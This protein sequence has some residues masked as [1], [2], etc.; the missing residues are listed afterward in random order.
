MWS[1]YVSFMFRLGDTNYRRP[2]VRCLIDDGHCALPPPPI[3]SLWR[4][5]RPPLQCW[6]WR[7][8]FCMWR[9]WGGGTSGRLSRWPVRGQIDTGSLDAL[10]WV[11]R[12]GPCRHVE[13]PRSGECLSIYPCRPCLVQRPCRCLSLWGAASRRRLRR[14]RV[15]VSGPSAAADAAAVVELGEGRVS[16]RHGDIDCR[17]GRGGHPGGMGDTAQPALLPKR[18][19]TLSTVTGNSAVRCGQ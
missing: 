7:C 8:H 3:K 11:L 10:Q 5:R 1:S 2:S 14:R 19:R 13:W 9:R 18:G 16:A 12:K 15:S 4:R 6:G 17:G